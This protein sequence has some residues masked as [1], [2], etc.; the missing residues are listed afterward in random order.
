VDVVEVY[1]ATFVDPGSGAGGTLFRLALLDGAASDARILYA[2]SGGGFTEGPAGCFD[3]PGSACAGKGAFTD[4]AGDATGVWATTEDALLRFDGATW[5]EEAVPSAT[6]LALRAV[7]TRG[8][9]LLLAAHVH[10]CGDDPCPGGTG[11]WR[12]LLLLH[13]APD[14]AWSEPRLLGAR[15]CASPTEQADCDAELAL[16]TVEDMVWAATG[17]VAVVGGDPVV[18][19]QGLT[20]QL[21]RLTAALGTP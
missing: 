15:A 14:G 2:P 17:V 16:Y 1:V 7:A 5:S 10:G 19:P 21:L 4:V 20:Q 6:P 12:S 11:A 8:G 3:A 13:R 9:H 18:T